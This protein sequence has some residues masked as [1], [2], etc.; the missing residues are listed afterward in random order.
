MGGNDKAGADKAFGF[1]QSNA[2]DYLSIPVP[3]T[4]DSKIPT[5]CKCDTGQDGNG[6]MCSQVSC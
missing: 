2:T 1:W 5:Y 4:K 6:G 3:A